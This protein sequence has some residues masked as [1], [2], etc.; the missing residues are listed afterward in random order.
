MLEAILVGLI[1]LAAALYAAWRLLPASLRLRVAHRIADWGRRPGH[2]A[3]LRRASMSVEATARRGVGA[4]SDCSAVQASPSQPPS[5]K[6]PH[7]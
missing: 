6:R 7:A 3:W 4:C 5:R 1:V 2:P